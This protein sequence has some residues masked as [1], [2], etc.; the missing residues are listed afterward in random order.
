MFMAHSH[1]F[2]MLSFISLPNR[3]MTNLHILEKDIKSLMIK[4]C[5]FMHLFYSYFLS[6]RFRNEERQKRKLV[7]FR[8]SL[9]SRHWTRYFMYW[10][11]IMIFNLQ[12]FIQNLQAR[13]VLEFSFFFFFFFFKKGNTTYIFCWDPGQKPKSNHMLFFFFK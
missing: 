9:C 12:S 5:T 4:I 6:E 2:I 7:Y 1:S 3:I 13:C 8:H 10:V 11:L